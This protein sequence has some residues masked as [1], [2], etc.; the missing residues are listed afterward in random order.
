MNRHSVSADASRDASGNFPR[1][2]SSGTSLG[3]KLVTFEEA[4]RSRAGALVDDGIVDLSA[5]LGELASSV[6]SIVERQ[7]EALP[8]IREALKKDL[9]K[10]PLSTKLLAPIP[11]PTSMRDGYAFRQHVE[12]AR[13]NRGLE[14][15]A[16]FDQF[17]VFYFTNHQAVIGPGD[18]R[19]MPRH[20]EKL[21]FELEAAI[22]V[23]RR[24]R[25]VKVSEA[26]G[27]VFGLTIMN[28]LSARVLQMDEMKL[29]LGPAKGKDFATAIGPYLITL[30][31]LEDKTKRGPNGNSY[32]LAMRAF[33]NDVKVS[34]GNLAD[35]NW[36]FAQILERVSYGVDIFPGDVIGSGTVGTGCFLEL[37]G[38]GITKNQWLQLG[39]IVRLEI[40]RLGT[41][42][43]KI[44]PE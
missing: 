14:M 8:A 20:L 29:S 21:D 32:D 39:D 13:K 33:V 36:T 44:V 35:M 1:A 28:D 30:D 40:D 2:A 38:S 7:D 12:T 25:N 26:D 17:P 9:P 27:Y 43:N 23:G 18:V 6:L 11:R 19:V 10:K 4:G 42:E 37:N 31:E 22:V 5:A 24:G 16:E 15:I 3:M 41:L 34:E